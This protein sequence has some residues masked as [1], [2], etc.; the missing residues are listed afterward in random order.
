MIR[1]GVVGMGLIGNRHM[2][3]IDRCKGVALGAVVEPDEQKRLALAG[4]G[5]ATFVSVEDMLRQVE[6]DGVVIATP[7]HLHASPAVACLQAGL[8][9]LVEKP[10]ATALEDADRI[11]EAAL[12]YQRHVLVGYNRRHSNSVAKAKELLDRSLGD[13]I[14]VSGQWTVRKPDSYFEP[15]WR[16][17][18]AA[19]PVMI[20]L[21]HDLDLMRYFCGEVES[22]SAI[23]T[24]RVRQFDK[25][26]VVAVTLRFRTGVLGTFIVSDSLHSPWSW[27]LATGESKEFK[28]TGENCYRFMGTDGSLEFP[29][30]VLWRSSDPDP[31]WMQPIEAKIIASGRSDDFFTQVSHFRDV[32]EGKSPPLATAS[33]GRETLR[34]T[35]AIQESILTETTVRL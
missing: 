23:G 4:K 11:V 18:K 14:A 13:L 2:A 16:R 21:T 20:N 22:V 29:N 7:S 31:S 27:E 30:L 35:L 32:I 1:L 17:N 12:R 19:G 5:I 6:L 25:E 8:H 9:V 15:D 34:A 26:D 10:I 28:A 3:S 33:D 24:S